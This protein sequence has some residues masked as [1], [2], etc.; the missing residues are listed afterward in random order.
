MYSS[1]CADFIVITEGVEVVLEGDREHEVI[2]L[3]GGLR[4]IVLSNPEDAQINEIVSNKAVARECSGW[5]IPSRNAGAR[6]VALGWGG[7][8]LSHERFIRM[9]SLELAEWY[10]SQQS[11]G[12]QPVVIGWAIDTSQPVIAIRYWRKIA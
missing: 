8:V 12:P 10:I 5:D 4:V 6:E 1:V 11:E 2:E 7:N 3:P 9:P